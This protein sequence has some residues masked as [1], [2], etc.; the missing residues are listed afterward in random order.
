MQNPNTP[1]YKSTIRLPQTD[2][3]MK[4]DLPIREPQIIAGWEKNNIY[5]KLQEKNSQGPGFTMPDGPPYAN[6]S[7]HIG[8]ALNKSLKDF[9]IKYKNM[10]GFSAPFIP[11]WDCHGLPIEH[12]VMKDLTDKKITKTDQEILALCREEAQKWV[13]H[14]REQFKRLGV[15]ADWENPYLTMSKPY[16]AEEVREFARAFKRGVIYQGVKPVY[17]NWTLKTALADAEIEYHDKVSPAIYVKF[18]VTDDKTLA[19]LGNPK[20]TTSFVIWTTTPWTLPANTGIALHPEFDYGVYSANGE[21]LVIAKSLKEFFEKDTG[22]TLQNLLTTVK[23]ADLELT[24]ARHPFL[25]RKSVVVLGDHVTA[26]AGTGAVHTAPGHGADDF[27]V[28]QKYNLPVI[29]PVAE[30]G[31][32]TDEYPEMQG[33]N[34]FKAN[35]VIIEKLKA[36]GHLLAHKDITHSYPHCW[37]SKTPLIFRTTAQWFI[38]IDQ[39]TSE[40][41]KNTLKAMEEVQFFPEWGK[42]RFEAMMQNRPDWCV[43]R[44][45]IWGVPIPIFYH[46]E[47]GKPLADFDIMMRAADVIEK[48]GIE[49]YYTTPAE[50]IVGKPGYRHGRDILDVWFDSGVCHAA[51]Q[52]RRGYKNAVADIYLEGSD[53]HRGWFNT[54]MLSSMATTGHPPFKALITHGFVNDSQGRKMSKSLGNVIDPNEIS[55][56]SGSEIVRLWAASVDYGTDV[57]CGKEELT[58]V[59]ETYRK[60]RNTMRFLLGA[61]ND[62]DAKE[63]VE[64][65]KMPMID[66]WMMHQL[67]KLIVEVTKAYDAYE[68]YRVYQLL[69][70]FFTVTLSA[71]Y[72]DILK[73]RLY[74]WKHNGL[75]RKAT[76]TVYHHVTTSVMR[77]MAPILTFLSEESYGYLKDKAHD[78][79]LLESFP[80]ANTLWADPKLDITFDELLKVRSEAQKKLEELRAAKTIGASLEASLKVSAEGGA[81]SALEE[82]NNSHAKCNLREF[83]IVSNVTLVKGPLSVSAVKADGEKCVRCWVY[84]KLST[85]EGTQGLCPK[86][87]E[88]LA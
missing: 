66:R 81:F 64:V 37:R 56:V 10:N 74:T 67:N 17:W 48:G 25:D 86:C 65:S 45:R 80:K 68:F 50:Q 3:P 77:M 76:Q 6:G 60:M 16:E 82:L 11:G 69:N 14:Q 35:P 54:S 4:G 15:L 83:F 62:F 58:R 30:N 38:G 63:A 61:I 26:D 85:A 29:N 34:I 36:S 21:N 57:G 71:T 13:N 46:E 79:V 9:V 28:G 88:A 23:G 43:S 2:F 33:M 31:T 87:V 52:A 18:N 47:T 72:M 55:K 32:Y 84:D 24:E 51:V 78:S 8:H 70:H 73:D 22:I 20:G 39:E 42:A 44:Q 53:Q 7:I 27:R 40:I 12:K 49:A 5:K 75:E 1:D 41:R 19:K 59:T